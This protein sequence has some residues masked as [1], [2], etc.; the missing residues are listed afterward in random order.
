MKPAPFKYVEAT[1]EKSLSSALAD[2]GSDARLLAGGQSLVP[3]MNFRL[4]SPEVIIDINGVSELDFIDCENDTLRIG[5]LTQK[6]G[7]QPG[8]ESDQRLPKVP[9][10]LA[11]PSLVQVP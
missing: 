7:R 5:S 11:S 2:S 6:I 3:M 9:Q 10:A 4:V 8:L 1:D